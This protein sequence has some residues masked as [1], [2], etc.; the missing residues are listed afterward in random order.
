M[1][2][3]SF[4]KLADQLQGMELTHVWRGYGSALFLEFGKLTQGERSDGSP[5]QPEGVV[6]IGIEWSWRIEHGLSIACGSWSDDERWEPAFE[7]LRN[8]HVKQLQLF[9]RLPEIALSLSDDLHV[10]SFS[11]TDGDPAWSIVDRRK[12]DHVWFSVREGQIHEV[13]E[14]KRGSVTPPPTRFQ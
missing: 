5:G 10:L 13:I 1:H 7:R 2:N 8:Q 9:G 4:S 3:L 12:S 14:P 11:T 6:S